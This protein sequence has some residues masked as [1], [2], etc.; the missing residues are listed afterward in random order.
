MYCR[1]G[2][3]VHADPPAGLIVRPSPRHRGPGQIK[4]G[5]AGLGA[6]HIIV[7]ALDGFASFMPSGVALCFALCASHRC[8]ISSCT[9][10][11]LA[12]LGLFR[13]FAPSPSA[14]MDARCSYRGPIGSSEGAQDQ[15]PLGG[16]GTDAHAFSPG[17][18]AL[19]KSPCV[20]SHALPGTDARQSAPS[21]VPFLL[22]TSLWARK[23]K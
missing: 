14:R 12:T 7:A 23:E 13:R 4:S 9:P 19:S 17:Q 15:A 11:T 22:V 16:M 2:I 10:F 18:D 1:K 3:G 20:P 6:S 5:C 21:G 8:V